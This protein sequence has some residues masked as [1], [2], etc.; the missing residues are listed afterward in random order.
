MI[1]NSVIIKTSRVGENINIGH[2]SIIY[3]NVIIKDNVKIGEY[4]VVGRTPS[5][6]TLMKKQINDIGCTIIHD[7]VVLSSNVIIYN[8][9]LIGENSLIGDNSSIFYN[10]T[11]GKNSLIS[12]CVTINSDTKIGD[13]TRI[14]DNTHITGKAIIGNNVFISAGVTTANDNSFGK[15]GYGSHI[16][17]PIIEDYVSVGLGA[18]ILPGIV[19][20]KGCIVA[21]GSV[22]TKD[23]PEDTVV[24]GNPAVIIRKLPKAL[25]RY[26]D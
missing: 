14:M 2:F 6:N 7:G 18:V 21:A 10:V 16:E 15:Y 17:G 1:E 8:N 9:V 23:V 25:R 11:V 24:F 20:K 12:R 22:V 3:E 4:T 5:I 26:N 19:L 13:Y